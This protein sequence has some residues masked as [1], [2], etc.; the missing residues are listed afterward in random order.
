MARRS[1]KEEEEQ[2][3]ETEDDLKGYF[4]YSSEKKLL[5]F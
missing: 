5:H 1:A 2:E 4:P 3:N